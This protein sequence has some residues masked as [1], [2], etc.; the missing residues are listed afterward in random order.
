MAEMRDTFG[1]TLI[2]LGK[3]YKN[4]YVMDADLNT[5]TRTVGYFKEYP[6]R[7][8]QAGICEQNM[9]GMA[10]GLALEGKIPLACTFATFL[11]LRALDQISTSVCYPQLNVKIV[12][13]YC[14]LFTS[15]TG[16][17]HQAIQDLAIFRAMPNIRVVDPCDNHELK[18]VMKA[19]LDYVG[20]TYQRCTIITPDAE[21][22]EGLT[23]EWGKG[24]QLV[25]GDEITIVSTG[26]TSQWAYQA[27]KQ[28][29]EE[30]ISARMLHMPSIKPFD[31]E[32]LEKAAKETKGIITVENHTVIGGLAGAV[33]E[34]LCEHTPAKMAR[35]GVQD[36]YGNT[37]SDKE[38]IEEYGIGTKHICQAVRDFL[39]NCK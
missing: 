30:G 25:D 8:V 14:G 23:F 22:T 36:R 24:H 13:S 37:G 19:T 29:H 6:Q 21:I 27:A 34:S 38:L 26:I 35:L 3:T 12:G 28:L 9:V 5:S 17:T 11:S 32:L 1:Q 7:Y 16:A 39:S 31:H 4:L 33:A 20:P 2:E 15:K 10:A 18:Q